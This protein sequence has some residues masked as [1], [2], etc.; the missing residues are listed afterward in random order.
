MEVIPAYSVNAV[1]AGLVCYAGRNVATDD[2]RP[3]LPVADI[4][5]AA[6]A[7]TLLKLWCDSVADALLPH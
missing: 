2:E 5:A 4:E 6:E 7:N 1:K 3:I